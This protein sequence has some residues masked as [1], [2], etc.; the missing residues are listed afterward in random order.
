MEEISEETLTVEEINKLMMA[1]GLWVAKDY[2][3]TVI[4]TFPKIM[5][6]KDPKEM[7]ALFQSIL[8]KANECKELVGPREETVILIKAKLIKMRNRLEALEATNKA[9]NSN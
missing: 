1:L 6:C 5:R 8:D 9:M 7:V 3:D 2:I 4:K